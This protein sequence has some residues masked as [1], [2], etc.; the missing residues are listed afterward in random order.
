M[1]SPDISLAHAP[2]GSSPAS[3]PAAALPAMLTMPSAESSHRLTVRNDFSELRRM[4]AWLAQAAI[5][6]G[7][8]RE[9]IFDLDLCANEVVTNI[10]SYA[11]EQAGG[12]EIDLRL[13]RASHGVSLEIQDDGRPFNPLAAAL[14]PPPANLEEAPIGG[15]GIRLI[16]GMA[17][18]CE[19]RRQD[20]MNVLT[21]TA[22]A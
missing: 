7:L 2:A 13:H 3:H 17:A 19:Y 20:G 11:Y 1:P 16:R 12:H 10:I 4:S 6:C 8:P 9:R 5:A 14:A 15:L 21:I 18:G 22:R